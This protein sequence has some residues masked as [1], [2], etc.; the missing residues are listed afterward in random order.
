MMRGIPID[1]SVVYP[2]HDMH[3]SLCKTY[4][5]EQTAQTGLLL[6][7]PVAHLP[8]VELPPRHVSGNGQE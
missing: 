2:G 3:F 8:F 7:C 4:S 5:G 1:L 6:S